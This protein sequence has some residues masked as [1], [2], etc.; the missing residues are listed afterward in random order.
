MLAL[1]GSG[2]KLA[3]FGIAKVYSL[4]N[5]TMDPTIVGTHN[6][7]SPKLLHNDMVHGDDED[8]E[9]EG[10]QKSDNEKRERVQ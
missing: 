3:D 5:I 8:D 7:L 9:E 4:D 10:E 2:W 6:Y 1:D